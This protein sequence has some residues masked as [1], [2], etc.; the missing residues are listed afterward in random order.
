VISAW[1]NTPAE[2]RLLNNMRFHGP[3]PHIVLEESPITG[4]NL[5]SHSSS[6]GA[7]MSRDESSSHSS[8]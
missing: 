3:S 7:R 2:V 4:G 8:S 1:M 5:S 6:S